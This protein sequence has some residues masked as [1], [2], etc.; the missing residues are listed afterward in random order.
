[1]GGFSACE[2]RSG[3]LVDV[4]V[5]HRG[6]HVQGSVGSDVIV[7]VWV[8]GEGGASGG[9]NSP[10]GRGC[11]PE[12]S[13]GGGSD[14]ASSAGRAP[15]RGRRGGYAP[16]AGLKTRR[17]VPGFPGRKRRGDASQPRTL[18]QDAT[19]G[20]FTRMNALAGQQDVQ[21]ALAPEGIALLQGPD[22][23][24]PGRGPWPPAETL[25]SSAEGCQALGTC[26][27]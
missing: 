8:I 14:G 15:G 11:T 16:A 23:A 25:Q 18:G 21:A 26:S 7:E 4:K 22:L 1:M 27:R 13:A 5:L 24:L 9:R 17:P 19:Q 12:W 3:S 2:T 10:P 6:P 20:G